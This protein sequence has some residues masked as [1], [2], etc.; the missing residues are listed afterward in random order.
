MQTSVKEDK[1]S[2]VL[3]S[4]K[5][6]IDESSDNHECHAKKCYNYIIRRLNQFN[7]KEAINEGLP[8]GSGRVESG[9]RNVIQK[10]LKVPGAW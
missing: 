1:L 7:Y 10:R 6:H 8:I 2:T 9:H 4:L 3:E 5:S